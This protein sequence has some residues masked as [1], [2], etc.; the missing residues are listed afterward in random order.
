MRNSFK[1][2]R[3]DNESSSFEVQQRRCTIE[4]IR[5]E[6]LHDDLMGILC[7]A[8]SPFEIA[9]L[10]AVYTLFVSVF[11]GKSSTIS[12]KS[13]YLL[14]SI[15]CLLCLYSACATALDLVIGNLRCC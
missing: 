4:R 10:V 12:S 13:T 3:K 11:T 15:R 6:Y 2:F 7:V 8:E 5:R 14:D 9:A 1:S